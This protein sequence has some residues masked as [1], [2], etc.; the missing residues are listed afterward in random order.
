MTYRW[1]EH[2]GPLDDSDRG[3]RTAAEIAAWKRRDPVTRSARMLIATKAT[4]RAELTELESQIQAELAEAVAA[5]RRAPWPDPKD[6][7]MDVF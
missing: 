5:A 1:L 6:L 4:T 7:L 3:Y 2:V